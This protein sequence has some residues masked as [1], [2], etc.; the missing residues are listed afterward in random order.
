MPQ[1][2]LRGKHGLAFLM[3][4]SAS[5]SKQQCTQASHLPCW[6]QHAQPASVAAEECN[7]LWT[8]GLCSPQDSAAAALAMEQ[9]GAGSQEDEEA[10]IKAELLKLIKRENVTQPLTGDAL[11][12][13]VLPNWRG[14][15][16]CGWACTSAPC[17]ALLLSGSETLQVGDA[18]VQVPFLHPFLQALSFAYHGRA[19]Q[20]HKAA[21]R[22]F[23]ATT[24][25]RWPRVFHL[26]K[27]APGRCGGMRRSAWRSAAGR[28]G[29]RAFRR[30]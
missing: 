13:R 1:C 10:T 24:K 27:L 3:L 7:T 6:K 18:K 9:Q 28:G 21:W 11:V 20:F 5:I 26:L 8:C 12:S 2:R 17:S 15:W 14:R 30:V 22:R 19:A 16:A 29:P 4:L 23:L 25:M